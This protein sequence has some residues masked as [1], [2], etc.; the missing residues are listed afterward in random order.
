MDFVSTSRAGALTT[1]HL[2]FVQPAVGAIQDPRRLDLVLVPLVGFDGA[3]ARLGMGGGHYDRCFRFRGWKRVWRHP[4]L[5]GVG[6]DFQRLA[7][8]QREPWDV[9]LDGAV[10]ESQNWIFT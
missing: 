7:S 2:G 8:I 5:L 10:T 4:K 9:P 3:G 1:H 6:Y